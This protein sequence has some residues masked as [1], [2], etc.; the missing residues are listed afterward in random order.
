MGTIQSQITGGSVADFAEITKNDEKKQN[1]H[2]V[3]L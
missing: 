2:K 3:K 1:Q